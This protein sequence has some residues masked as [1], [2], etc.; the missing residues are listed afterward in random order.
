[1]IKELCTDVHRL[2]QEMWTPIASELQVPW[3]AVEAMHWSMGEH[4][5]ARRANVVP[6][7]LSTPNT[8]PPKPGSGRIAQRDRMLK[9]NI[10]FEGQ[11]LSTLGAGFVGVNDGFGGMGPVSSC[12][13]LGRGGDVRIPPIKSEQHA[14]GNDE[15]CR[16]DHGGEGDGE[17]GR[18]RKARLP[19]FAELDGEVQAF[20]GGRVMVKQEQVERGRRISG[21]SFVMA[22]QEHG[23][24]SS[25]G[26]YGSE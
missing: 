1:M 6:F 22:N 26:S 11:D 9:S 24:R 5:M 7:S 21:G 3:R 4:E 2:K 23:R 13:V 18:G 17:G 8:E 20:A 16:R 12:G 19:G 25:G 15:G 14:M 10:V